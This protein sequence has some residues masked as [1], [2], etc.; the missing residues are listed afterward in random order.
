MKKLY[1]TILSLFIVINLCAQSD[2]TLVERYREM[3]L[4]YNHDLRAAQKNIAASME[5]QQSARADLLPKLSGNA[6]VKY[7]GNP[8]EL[9]LS[10][11]SFDQP[12]R[13]QGNDLAY[14]A[15]VTLMQPIYTGGQLLETI[16]L[17]EHKQMMATEQEALTRAIVCFQTDVQYWNTVAQHEV[18]LVSKA[19][20]ESVAQ[21]VKTI[22]DRVEVGMADPQDLLMAEVRLNA[23]DYQQ[24]Q[25]KTRFETS[26]MALNAMVGLPLDH[27]T[28][29]ENT[30][31]AATI[32]ADSYRDV[33]DGGRPEIGIAQQQI[34][35]AESN[36][37]INQSRFRPKLYV[38]VDGSYSSPGYNFN[39]DLDPN[40][41][42]YAK[43][44]VPI[45]EWGKRKNEKRASR[46][47][48]GVAND[49]Y[50][51]VVDNVRLEI[52]TAN[53]TLDESLQQV[54]LTE[55]SLEKAYNNETM[56]TER[57]SEGRSS[58]LEVIDAQTYRQNAQINFV[59]AK[60]SAQTAYASLLKATNRYNIP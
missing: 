45:F 29:I 54:I 25:A 4:N 60:A 17:A 1:Y 38:G 46:Y 5:L 36:A 13:F 43:L 57:Y 24:S 28:E 53:T 37:V 39:K 16:K 14:G 9:N 18:W 32:A 41:A 23:A 20:R 19:Y 26:R 44:S 35:I 2:S 31:P 50:N 22:N 56:A 42:V 33:N 51:K 11:P 12:M 40:Y 10:L 47:K 34:N 30:I 52:E 21:L 6:N 7:T 27:L 58:I 3:A 8:M 49:N 55:N 59:Q 48:V 15:S